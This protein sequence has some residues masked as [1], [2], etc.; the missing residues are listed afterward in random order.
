MLRPIN[1]SLFVVTALDLET[2][3]PPRGWKAQ[4]CHPTLS[5]VKV[6]EVLHYLQDGNL[7]QAPPAKT[8]DSK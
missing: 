3:S 7:C 4:L 2:Q 5:P 8:A 1:S 6:E